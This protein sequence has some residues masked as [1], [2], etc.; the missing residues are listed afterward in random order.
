MTAQAVADVLGKPRGTAKRLLWELSR[1]E[2]APVVS[3]GV[4]G[5]RAVQDSQHQEEGRV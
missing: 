1:E 5:Y 4:K 2:P 3:E